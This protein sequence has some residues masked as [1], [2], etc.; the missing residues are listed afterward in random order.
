[1][2]ALTQNETSMLAI[3]IIVIIIFIIIAERPV[4]EG[5]LGQ[6]TMDQERPCDYGINMKSPRFEVR[7]PRLTR[8]LCNFQY[9]RSTHKFKLGTFN[10]GHLSQIRNRKSTN[11]LFH[12]SH[13]HWG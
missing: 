12:K 1:M 10:Y 8:L 3:A 13:S 9:N 2:P 4:D 6:A 11:E 7:G 5:S